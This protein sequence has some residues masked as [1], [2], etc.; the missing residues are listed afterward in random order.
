MK[1]QLEVESIKSPL[2]K[3]GKGAELT[4]ADTARPRCL[5]PFSYYISDVAAFEEA[6]KRKLADL[7]FKPVE[8]GV[9]SME[10]ANMGA[11]IKLNGEISFPAK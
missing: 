9:T 2:G 8:I 5:I 7:N 3:T 11:G 10:G 4:L 1:L 6:H